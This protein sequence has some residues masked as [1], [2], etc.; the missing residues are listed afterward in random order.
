MKKQTEIE[1]INILKNKVNKLWT[2]KYRPKTLNDLI[3]PEEIKNFIKTCIK[4]QNIPNILLVG[5][6]GT[7]KNSIINVLLYNIDCSVL[8]INASAERGIDTIREN[9]TDFI[10]TSSFKNKIKV[11]LLNEAD[12]LTFEAQDSLRDLMETDKNCSFILT[13]NYFNRFTE[14]II[15]RCMVFDTSKINSEKDIKER[16]QY[17]CK[18]EGINE[19]KYIND[20]IT[21]YQKDI[22]SMINNIQYN[23]LRN[24]NNYV[25]DFVDEM[26][27]IF[28]MIF[29]NCN[30]IKDI[31]DIF[32]ER[33]III[34]E[35]IY[36][37]LFKYFLN[38]YPEKSDCIICIAE[39]AYKGKYVFDQELQLMA[40]LLTLKDII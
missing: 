24:D 22:R 25:V 4:Q 17:I 18:Q 10:N 31:Q 26:E 29:N 20:L 19:E 30:N 11:I 14:A 16:L 40:C 39:Y 27:D 7:G 6:V 13:G 2:E 36:S 33:D 37:L 9:V 12:R 3:A 23:Y 21:R 34:N 35:D 5:S 15:S 28:D 32:K 8:K 38:K 1:Q